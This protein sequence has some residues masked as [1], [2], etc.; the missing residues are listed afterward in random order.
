MVSE[1][2]VFV[3]VKHEPN[4]PNNGDERISNYIMCGCVFAFMSTTT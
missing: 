4:I 2:H 3:C 1:E